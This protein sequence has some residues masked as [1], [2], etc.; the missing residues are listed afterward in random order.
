MGIP[1]G[2]K[3]IAIVREQAE[4]ISRCRLTFHVSRGG[5][6]GL[7]NQNIVDSAIFL[8]NNDAAGQGSL[9]VEYARLSEGFFNHLKRHPVPLEEAAIRAINNNSMALD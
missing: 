2:G 5:R 3:N 8:E 9:F 6:T 1:Q 4:R 7:V